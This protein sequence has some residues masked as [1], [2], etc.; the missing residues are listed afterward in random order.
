MLASA[1]IIIAAL[2]PLPQALPV[3]Q[4]QQKKQA[5]AVSQQ[6]Q[7]G[8]KVQALVTA[9]CPCEKCCGKFSEFGLTS[10]GRDARTTRGVAV[11]PKLIKYGSNVEIPG[12]GR[13]VADDT[14]GAMR[15][16]GKKG[17]VHI[18]LRFHNHN[19]ARQFGRKNLEVT[20]YE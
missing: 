19:E 18:D 16:S 14:G 3:L 5:E 4:P 8:R 2:S 11:D 17:I 1:S 15:Q 10:R 7:A 12:Y 20:I 6:P 13:F 9:Y